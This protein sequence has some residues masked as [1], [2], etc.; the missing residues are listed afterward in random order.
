MIA[1]THGGVITDPA[2]MTRVFK[3]SLRSVR[4]KQ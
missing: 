4:A 3:A 1:P 2:E